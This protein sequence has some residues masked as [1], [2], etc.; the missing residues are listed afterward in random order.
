[1]GLSGGASLPIESL[2][3]FESKFKAHILEVYGLT[4][5]TGLV[6]A[7]PVFGIRK[8]GS[9]GITVSGVQTKVVTESGEECATGEVG[10]LLFRGPNATAGYWNRKDETNSRIVHGWVHT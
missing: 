9:I 8:P 4:E 6:T 2:R 3:E 1:M 5:S 7:N 10:E